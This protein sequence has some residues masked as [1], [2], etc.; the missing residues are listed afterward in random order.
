MLLTIKA[1]NENFDEGWAQ[2]LLQSVICQKL[3][4]N[5]DIPIYS[6]VTTGDLWEFG[7][8]ENHV[9]IRH[10]VPWAIQDI[11]G[12]L[13]ILDTLFSVCEKLI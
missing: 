1:K 8:L 3:N 13:G 9:F 12:L 2:A 10:P 6:I 11:G 5:D 7:K 4:E